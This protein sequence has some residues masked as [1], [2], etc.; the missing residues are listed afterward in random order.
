MVSVN[1]AFCDRIFSLTIM[2]VYMKNFL[3]KTGMNPGSELISDIKDARV[4]TFEM[5]D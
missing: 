4:K 5:C 1:H 3:H 2:E